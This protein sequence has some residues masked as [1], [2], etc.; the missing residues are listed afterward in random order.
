MTAYCP[1]CLE[2][3]VPRNARDGRCAWCRPQGKRRHSD[4]RQQTNSGLTEL[5]AEHRGRR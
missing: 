4:P 5:F 1:D 2:V 3:E